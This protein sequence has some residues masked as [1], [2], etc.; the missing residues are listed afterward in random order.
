MP[1][2]EAPKPKELSTADTALEYIKLLVEQGKTD[3]QAVQVLKD[4]LKHTPVTEAL[5]QVV[6]TEPPSL[7]VKILRRE[8]KIWKNMP[9]DFESGHPSRGS[10]VRL[11]AAVVGA[12]AAVAGVGT[13]VVK[14]RIDEILEPQRFPE[15]RSAE[16]GITVDAKTL[17]YAFQAGTLRNPDGS[18]K[19]EEFPLLNTNPFTIS[20][21]ILRRTT[22]YLRLGDV[23]PASGPSPIPADRFELYTHETSS[24]PLPIQGFV[25]LENAADD[26]K[27]SR[28]LAVDPNQEFLGAVRGYMF[29]VN[30]KDTQALIGEYVFIMQGLVSAN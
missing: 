12:T 25:L 3:A 8:W 4:R 10:V 18:I 1:P 15:F 23:S 27:R 11:L 29:H 16:S 9:E 17:F 7:L 2:E 24:Q 14:R 26:A 20:D 28:L 22:N 6:D 30:N 19:W 13:Y 21:V 5:T